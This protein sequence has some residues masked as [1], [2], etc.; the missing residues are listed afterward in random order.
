[1]SIGS[2]STHQCRNCEYEL[3]GLPNRGR[4]PECGNEYDMKSGKGII[5]GP[6]DR[7]RRG[8]R[9][10]ARIRT[11]LLGVAVLVVMSCGGLLSLLVHAYS[12]NWLKPLATAG[13][14]SAVLLM[15]MVLSYLNERE[16]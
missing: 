1:M 15:A 9:I 5:G 10:M 12:G 8:E 11:I 14:F 6:S 2:S 7:H 13:M 3:T 16:I 4:C